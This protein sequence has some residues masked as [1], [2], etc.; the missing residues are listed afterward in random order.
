MMGYKMKQSV[1]IF[2]E[3]LFD[4]FPDGTQVLGGAPFNVAWHL[5]ALNIQPLL[6]SSIGNDNL[7]YKIQVTLKQWGISQI[8]IQIQ[9]QYSTGQVQVTLEDNQPR[10]SI[11]PNQAFDF[12]EKKQL[13]DIRQCELLYHGSLALRHHTARKAF[14]A[15]LRYKKPI[16]I[17]VNLRHPW[18]GKREVLQYLQQ[19]TWAKLNQEE[20]EHLSP[21]TI[22]ANLEQ[23]IRALAQ[24]CRL[25]WLVITLGDKGA[26]GLDEYQNLIRIPPSRKVTVVDTVG[27]GDSFSAILLLGLL[28]KWSLT[29]TLKHAQYFAES[30][31]QIRGGTCSD[32]SL[33]QHFYQNILT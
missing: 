7:S 15:L 12:I 17:D 31:V 27:A 13:V 16:F 32:K 30:L 2:G 4:H 19:A 10:F 29:K 21:I 3:I 23:K 18:W 26:I 28:K 20:L 33:Y 6:I 5:Q 1:A 22:G 14:R 24:C 11:P 8:G 9:P 25:E